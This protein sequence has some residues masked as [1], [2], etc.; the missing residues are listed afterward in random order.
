MKV[1]LADTI[2]SFG[3]ERCV[4]ALRN[5]PDYITVVDT[6]EE[7]D[8]VVIQINGRLEHTKQAIQEYGKPY[9]LFQH[10]WLSTMNPTAEEWQEVWDNSVIT[11]SHYA[12]PTDKLVRLPLGV[13]SEF[14]C[15]HL[16][17]KQYLICTSGLSYLTESVRECI[18]AAEIVGGRV[19][20]LGPDHAARGHKHVKC[21]SGITDDGLAHLYNRCKFVSGLRRIEGFELPC[22]EGLVCGARPVMFDQPHYKDWFGTWAEYIPE[23]PRPDVVASLVK[24]FSEPVRKVTDQERDDARRLF[25][26]DEFS[27]SFYEHLRENYTGV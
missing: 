2:R 25:S 9:A 14:S 13:G 6:P 7:A 26:W 10:A 11:G 22:A 1:F 8:I 5:A 16:K 3:I 20:H 15:N 27:S 21:V 19:L 12:L 4:Q 17:R 23:E 18:K 24:L